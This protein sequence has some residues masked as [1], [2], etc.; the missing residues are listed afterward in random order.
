MIAYIKGAI[1]FKSPTYV[2]VETAG[3]GYHI[4]ISLNTYTAIEKLEQVQLLTHLKITE[5]A[6]A[7][8]GFADEAERRLFLMLISVGGVGATTAQVVLSAMSPDEVRAAIIGEHEQAFGKVKGIGPKTAKR[9]IIE[10]KD[11]VTKDGGSNFE[12]PLT[13]GIGPD[14]KMREDA[15]MALMTLGYPRI[16]VQ[17]ALNAAIKESPTIAKVDDLIKSALRLLA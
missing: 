17:K 10:L 8:Y 4:H 16:P 11:K 14:N 13:G 9:I 2:I 5:D 12:L 1:S 6:H 3:I 15:L 7:L